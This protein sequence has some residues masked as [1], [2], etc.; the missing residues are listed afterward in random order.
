MKNHTATSS[1]IRPNFGL[2]IGETS[3]PTDED[4]NAEAFSDTNKKKAA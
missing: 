4:R 2:D 3:Y 1:A